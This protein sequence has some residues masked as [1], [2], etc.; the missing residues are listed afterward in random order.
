[1]YNTLINNKYI[2]SFIA[3]CINTLSFAP[4]FLFPFVIISFMII[5]FLLDNI[6]SIREI[7]II[8]W[9]YG[10]GNFVT[11]LYWIIY[12]LLTD[13][14]EFLIL[15]PLSNIIL[16]GFLAIY[17]CVTLLV[18]H[19]MNKHFSNYYRYI[20]LAVNWTSI[21]YARS[22]LFSG[23][24]WNL[25]GY[26]VC[27][28]ESL[29]QIISIIGIYGCSCLIIIISSAIYNLFYKRYI[30]SMIILAVTSSIY[31]YG[32][33]RLNNIIE[34][35]DVNLLLVQGNISQHDMLT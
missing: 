20:I 23:F 30:Y 2:V 18:S 29:S 16:P 17:P 5:I 25:T 15:S 19:I 4:F 22:I 35:E 11:G 24:P 32:N 9:L 33:Q 10:F 31:L 21:E 6:K 34:Y 3:G 14:D 13:S 12:A 27:F 28:S 1:M 7:I 8:G 26:T